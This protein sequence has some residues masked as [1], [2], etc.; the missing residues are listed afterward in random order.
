M[1]ARLD[2]NDM[3]AALSRLAPVPRWSQYIP[4]I[5]TAKQSV[6]LSLPNKEA[7]YG[8]AA[9]GGKSDALLMAALQYVDVPHY[10]AVLFRRKISDANKANAILDRA[11]RWLR[12]F[13]KEGVIFKNNSYWFPSGA[14][15]AFGY[16]DNEM[17]K[18]DHQ[19]AEY[20]FIGFDELTQFPETWYT[21]LFSRLRHARCPEHP[22][23]TAADPN[24]K[25]CQEYHQLS[26]VPLR[27]RAASNPGGLGHLWV[28][29]RFGIKQVLLPDGR[30]IYRGTVKGRPYVPAFV[31]D[32]PF[33]DEDYHD[34]LRQM[35]PVTR[36]QLLRGD[37]GVTADGRFK[38]SWVKRYSVRGTNVVLG[39]DGR[40]PSYPL[41]KCRCFCTVDPAASV[42]EGPGDAL[43]WEREASWT[44][45]STWLVTPKYD[46]IWWDMLRFQEEIPDILP[47]L[48]A[49]YRRHSPEYF[50]VESNGLGIGVCQAASRAGLPIRYLKPR[51]MDKLARA[52]DAIIRMERGQIYL[53]NETPL[54]HMVNE[55]VPPPGLHKD[56]LPFWKPISS[57]DWLEECEAELFTWFG[58][59]KQQ[60]DQIDTLA[61]AAMIVSIEASGIEYAKLAKSSTT[62]GQTVP[63]STPGF[64]K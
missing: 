3:L 45:I 33:L 22:K 8:G 44:V 27:M 49:T 31:T 23:G 4:H 57:L 42:R 16:L 48:Q 41:S 59:P 12:Q 5:P 35:D 36:D 54:P 40:G 38:R 50:G 19:S 21:Y 26:N 39:A 47:A 30:Y 7:F 32:N 13:E 17:D 20:Q 53:P 14:R 9:G 55:Q 51:T 2:T 56:M 46:L 34:S 15:I 62:P 43:I 61:Y 37:W 64:F 63:K 28:K 52:N 10:S 60:A 18:F 6:F 24:C 11:H 29:K 58:H 1:V 25:S